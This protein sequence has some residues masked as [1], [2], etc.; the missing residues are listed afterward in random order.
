M[1]QFGSIVAYHLS[2]AS[3]GEQRVSHYTM[4]PSTVS[5]RPLLLLPLNG[6][7]R[8]VSSFP[9][10]CSGESGN[11]FS[12]DIGSSP[13]LQRLTGSLNVD[14]R[15]LILSRPSPKATLLFSPAFTGLE[16]GMKFHAVFLFQSSHFLFHTIPF[17]GFSQPCLYPLL[18][19]AE[20]Q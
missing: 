1:I 8:E 10:D 15:P 9:V 12:L 6:P 20:G 2:W 3:R 7:T 11:T 4:P 14:V 19:R 13:N 18:D 5:P 17:H 16:I